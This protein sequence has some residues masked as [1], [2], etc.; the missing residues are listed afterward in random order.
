M[1]QADFCNEVDGQTRL[2]LTFDIAAEVAMRQYRAVPF[3]PRSGHRSAIE[4]HGKIADRRALSR[5]LLS[6]SY[7]PL[8]EFH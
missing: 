7:S 1:F 2:D 6:Q 5:K 4:C 8:P 3:L